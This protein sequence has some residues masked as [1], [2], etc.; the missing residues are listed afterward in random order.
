MNRFRLVGKTKPQ[1][2]ILQRVDAFTIGQLLV[3]PSRGV[4]TLVDIRPVEVGGDTVPAFILQGGDPG[5]WLA[6]PISQVERGAVRPLASQGILN[7]AL[8][9]LGQ[10]RRQSRAIW[11]RRALDYEAKIKT[12]DPLMLAEVLRDLHREGEQTFSE[13]QIFDRA[14][15][16]LAAEFSPVMQMDDSQARAR[17]LESFSAKTNRK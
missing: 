13:K 17:I 14:L 15:E 8:A 10:R 7:E 9:T 11:S 12:G 4:F 16:R 6:V 3:Y 2:E 5:A 1:E